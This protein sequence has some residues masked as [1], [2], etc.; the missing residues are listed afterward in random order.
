MQKSLIMLLMLM[1]ISRGWGK[2]FTTEYIEFQLPPGWQ[3][4]LEGTEWVCQS[5][6]K[7]R[8]KEAIIIM[9]AKEKGA[10]DT[11]QQYENYLKE[12]KQYILPNR[13]TQ[14]SEPKYTRK[15]KINNNLWVDSLHLASEVPGFYTRYMA[16]VKGDL[17]IAV[18]FSVAKD[19]YNSY[20]QLFQKV[21]ESMRAFAV[22]KGQVAKTLGI[23]QKR[24]DLLSNSGLLGSGIVGP[25]VTSGKQRKRQSDDSGDLF[26]YGILLAALAGFIIYKKKK[27]S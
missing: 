7:G 13:K 26:F 15:T 6:S 27:R 18:T 14:V 1:S 23:K 10:Q 22:T 4:S 20:Q 9:A 5:Q 19:H 16:T 17:G 25:K 24:Q 11:L 21:I 8:K 2:S 3:C 12:K